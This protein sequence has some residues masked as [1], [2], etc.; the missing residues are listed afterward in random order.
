MDDNQLIL[1]MRCCLSTNVVDI[2]KGCPMGIQQGCMQKLSDMLEDRINELSERLAIITE[3]HHFIDG[4]ELLHQLLLLSAT[5]GGKTGPEL[6][7]LCISE[8][9][10]A[11]ERG[12]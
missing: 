6:S 8:I 1:A 10:K 12:V 11:C 2:C 3:G 4:D 9:K 7:E 5:A